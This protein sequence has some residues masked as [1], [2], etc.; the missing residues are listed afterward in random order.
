MAIYL[1]RHGECT[2]NV[3]KIFTC[4]LLDPELTELGKAQ[5]S[6][7]RVKKG[8]GKKNKKCREHVF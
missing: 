1:Q 8:N 3:R 6:V 4:R 2:T 5:I 7:R